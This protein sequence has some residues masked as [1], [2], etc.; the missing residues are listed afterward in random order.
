[1]SQT[2]YRKYRPKNFSE[3][4]GQRHIVQ[5]LI[6]SIKNERLAQA[7]LFAGPRG[8]G[9]TSVAR[10][11]A[12]TINCQNLKKNSDTCEKCLP[13]KL[14]HEGKSFDIIEIDAASN[15]G[16]DNIR[17]LRET[18]KLPAT[19]LKYK[20][21]I[22]DE[23]H[24]LSIGA[25]NA[26]LKTLEEPPAHVVFILATTE[27]HKVPETIISRCQRFDFARLPIENIIEKLSL[28]AK[29]EKVK[30]DASALEMIAIASEGGMRDAESLLGQVISL[31]D[32]DITLKE[33]Q[34]ILGITDKKFAH[35]I[36]EK[37]IAKDTRVAIEK[38]N[39][40]LLDGYDLEVFN[41]SL[42][43]YLRQLMLLKVNPVL[44][45]QFSYEMTKEQ[46]EKMQ[47]QSEKIDLQKIIF[48]INLFLDAQ[49]KIS[50]SILP[51]L[52][53]E[54]AIIKATNEFPR[55]V[56]TPLNEP[57]AI[58]QV[59]KK[60]VY[61][62]PKQTENLKV[63]DNSNKYEVTVNKQEEIEQ[64]E[65][66]TIDKANNKWK[67]LLVDIKPFNHSLKAL[68]TNCQIYEVKK[69]T[70]TLATPY[71]FYRDKLNIPINKTTVEDVFSKI[72]GTKIDI[73]VVLCKEVGIEP[74]NTELGKPAPEKEKQQD[75]LLSSALKIIGGKVVEE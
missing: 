40:L 66:L 4:I 69:N 57:T 54:I 75:S 8:T 44:V 50:S 55:P 17:E 41:K 28:I 30:I 2:L 11:F 64:S 60:I 9:K 19:V 12:K 68:L 63:T 70:V 32:R 59:P 39:A 27:I 35:E 46:A 15:T 22:I 14:A 1:M 37:I 10:I 71:D 25:F 13:C 34:E 53:L 42:I 7:Y 67:Q 29:N 21:Y 73:K 23:V 45:S 20:I 47:K 3:V 52:P 36:M 62:E 16:V 61:S 74:K 33:V 38:I 48:I 72:L 51:Q 65:Y 31:E 43:N 18:V 26:L 49:S 6:N 58:N 24:M 56:P 5:T